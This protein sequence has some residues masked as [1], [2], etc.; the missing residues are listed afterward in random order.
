MSVLF[1][2]DAKV[3]VQGITGREGTARTGLMLDYG[4]NVVAGCTPGKRG[5]S[6]RGIPVFDTVREAGEAVGTIDV[7]VIYVPAPAVKD[8]AIEA[9]T[10]GIRFLCIVPDRVPVYDVMEIA[11]VARET[12]GR[13][14]GPN[15]LGVL[16]PDVAILGMIGGRAE[17][18][19]SWFTSG[20]V[21]ICSRSGGMTSSAGYYLSR[22]GLGVSAMVHV[23]GDSIVGT[24]LDEVCLEFEHDPSTEAILLIGEIGGGQEERVAE[25]MRS[26]RVAKPVVAFVGGRAAK[27]GVRFSHAGAIIDGDHGTHAGKVAALRE[28]GA[29]IVDDLMDAPAALRQALK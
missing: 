27:E 24:P 7:S 13:F 1:G 17:S 14:V 5:R 4:T 19:R 12:G 23:G 25:H 16:I 15:T 8:A 9:L 22:D 6:V 20:P 26:G 2:P 18:A 21:G 28:A 3:L 29:T 10:A 11:A